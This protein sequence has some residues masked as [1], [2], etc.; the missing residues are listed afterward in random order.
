M[1][2]SA[3]FLFE[4][5]MLKK[6]P[7]TGYQFLG[8]GGESVA[9]HSFRTA[10]IGYVLASQEPDADL[11]KVIL[12]CLFH[13]LPE[14]RT[15]DHNYVNKRYVKADEEKALRDQVRELPQ[16]DEIITLTQEFNADGTLEAHLARDADQLDLI[17]ELKE[18]LDLGNPGAG[19]WLSFAVQRLITDGA[20]GLAK[21]VLTTDRSEWWFDKQTDW[22]VNGPNNQ[23]GK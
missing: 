8:S 1:K 19:D 7:R 23:R 18:Q 3:K 13:D 5:G 10:V 6:T 9:D 20:K 4:V 21:E 17:F 14:A 16:G 2:R 22:W 11:N 12:M 15:G